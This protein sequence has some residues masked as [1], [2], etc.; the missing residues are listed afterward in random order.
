MGLLKN[1]EKKGVSFSGV[2][3][4]HIQLVV[5]NLFIFQKKAVLFLMTIVFNKYVCLHLHA[6]L[7]YTE[8][9]YYMNI[10]KYLRHVFKRMIKHQCY[11]YH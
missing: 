5:L 7:T 10:Q 9:N 6:F 11:K 4:G 2:I 3:R 1:Q 8:Y